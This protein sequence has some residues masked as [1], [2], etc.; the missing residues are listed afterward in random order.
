M[1]KLLAIVVT[2]LCLLVAGAPTVA[3]AVGSTVACKSSKKIANCTVKPR[4]TGVSDFS[5]SSDRIFVDRPLYMTPIGADFEYFI[6]GV[7]LGK[8]F[9][10]YA[11]P[12]AG[13]HVLTL[14]VSRV[15]V[16][17]DQFVI[18]PT[19]TVYAGVSDFSYSSDRVFVDF[20]LNQQPAT[21]SFEYKVDGYPLGENFVGYRFLGPG[22]HVLELYVGGVLV[23]TDQFTI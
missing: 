21:A 2:T 7:S 20:P 14:K 5:T 19:Q 9:V 22:Q 8:N 17:T 15:L 6:D 10:G 12:G 16:D 3:S 18:S 1:R 11:Y 23:D 13:T 4:A